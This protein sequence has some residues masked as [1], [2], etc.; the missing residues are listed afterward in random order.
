[1]N[2]P[3]TGPSGS[4][5]GTG[6][7]PSPRPH[8]LSGEGTPSVSI[9][10]SVAQERRPSP[11]S[12]QD[13][14]R[15]VNLWTEKE[16]LNGER[17]SAFVL[18]L[19]TRGC[20]WADLKGCTMCGYARDTLGRSATEAEIAEQVERALLE[21]HDEPYV[22]VFSSGS[23]FD[24]REVPVA[25][26][27]ALASAFRGRARRLLVETLPEFVDQANVGALRES[28]GGE[29]EVALGL[30]SAQEEVLRRAVN[31]NSPPSS[32]FD[33]AGRVHQGGGQAKAYLLLKPPY[34]TEREAIEDTVK[35]VGIASQHFD[36]LSINPVHL[37]GGTVVEHLFR[38]GLYRPPWIW[39]LVETLVRGAAERKKGTRLVSFPTSGGNRRG[40][41]NCLSCD[42]AILSA[43]EE[44]SL[45]QDFGPLERL[46]TCP[47]QER[48]RLEQALEPLAPETT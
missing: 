22:K 21:Y 47:C 14:R 5:P 16:A 26:R 44:A 12:S 9:A 17:T 24:P 39:S 46:P 37:Q 35:S 28:F 4:P 23:F 25:S 43:I 32:Y 42:R 6:P 33:A 48:W 45:S 19:K 40:V 34:L 29:V 13:A 7:G 10:R 3:P 27:H 8:G 15:Y 18:I 11:A 31:K 1:M 2:H 41:H 38:R 30:E 36:T 20:Y